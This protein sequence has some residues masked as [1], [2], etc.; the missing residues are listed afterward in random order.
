MAAAEQARRQGITTCVDAGNGG[1]VGALSPVDGAAYLATLEAGRL[2][3]RMQLMPSID[4]LREMRTNQADGF[5][6]GLDLGMRSGF[7]SDWLGI[8]AQKVVLDGGMQVE[9]ARM[10]RARTR[11][12]ATSASGGRT[13]R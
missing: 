10:T 9:T 2:P 12:R 1:E 11:G 3:V 4:V 5:R 13:L 8:A 7:G 6:R